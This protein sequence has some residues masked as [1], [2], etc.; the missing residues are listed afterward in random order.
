MLRDKRFSG[1]VRLPH[2]IRPRLTVCVY[3]DAK[4]CDE[5]RAISAPCMSVDDL[6]CL[7]KDRKK[8]RRLDHRY[9]AFLA[10]ETIIRQIPRLLGPCL[11]KVGKFPT[12]LRHD[13]TVA[14]K[15]QQVKSTLK[16]QLKKNPNICVAIG[17]VD[18]DIE[19]LLATTTLSVNFIVGLTRKHW[20]SIE[21]IFI[22]STMGK[23]HRLY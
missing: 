3:G 2:V 5:A 13:E 11:G 15:I 18:M 20:Q 9:D 10:S 8:V 12:L 14:D 22:K 7:N 16:V 6:K 19:Q 4:H 1:T 21:K 23:S 17:N